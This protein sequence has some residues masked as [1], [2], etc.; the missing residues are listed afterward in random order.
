MKRTRPKCI[1]NLWRRRPWMGP[2]GS[3]YIHGRP[4]LTPY[5]SAQSVSSRGGK[6]KVVGQHRDDKHEE[7]VLE[8]RQFADSLISEHVI[9][10]TEGLYE[11][12]SFFRSPAFFICKNRLSQNA[13][14][15]PE[16]MAAH[17]AA[18]RGQCHKTNYGLIGTR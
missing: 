16:R 12:G 7:L 9:F 1:V 18:Q 6:I 14:R 4:W 3:S 11:A 13:P 10:L 5:A 2:P 17:I 8:E 15:P